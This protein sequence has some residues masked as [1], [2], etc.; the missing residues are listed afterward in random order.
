AASAEFT[1]DRRWFVSL[2]DQS[3]APPLE[4]L[5]GFLSAESGGLIPPLPDSLRPLTD[6]A[7]PSQV[8]FGGDP[9]A[10]T[11]DVAG[12]RFAQK[13][14]WTAV[15]G[16]TVSGFSVAVTAAK[17]DGGW[18]ATGRLLGSVTLGTG[19]N[20]ATFHVDMPIPPRAGEDWTI[21]LD[22]ASAIRIPT[23][24]QVLDLAGGAAIPLPDGIATLGGLDVTAL[25]VSFDPTVPALRHMGLRFAQ[26]GTW[27]IIPGA[28]GGAPALAASG[29]NAS[30]SVRTG[31]LAALGRAQGEITVLGT[32]V[33]FA[34]LKP[35]FDGDW[36]LRGAWNQPVHVPGLAD[37]A[38][39][40]G[41]DGTR[42]VLSAV[43][44]F[45]Q[46]FDLARLRLRFSGDTGRLRLV[47]FRLSTPV[48]WSVVGGRL[49][50][51]DVFAE[52]VVPTAGSVTGA[53]GGLV[54]VAGVT[55]QLRASRPTEQDPWTF[56]GGL[57]APV[58][59]D[60]L[61]AANQVSDAVLALPADAQS[62]WNLPTLVL[63]RADVT[64]VPQTGAYTFAAAL[65]FDGWSF[66]FGAATLALRQISGRVEKAGTDAPLV[67]RVLG[68]LTFASLDVQLGMQIGTAGTDTV[69][70]GSLTA[71][72]AQSLAV[73]SVAD[74]LAGAAGDAQWGAIVPDGL[75]TALSG[76]TRRPRKKADA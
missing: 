55:A 47:G 54:T 46:G 35:A 33:D 9:F 60:L 64:A 5:A 14:P 76:A 24:R 23:L 57:F 66:G 61:D 12:F 1:S 43:P 71:Q 65:D 75:P 6:L 30:L 15:P 63:R 50:V 49:S 51:H 36:E 8:F 19:E 59:L 26:D 41:R 11:L 22:E 34:L 40:M 38:E 3:A 58:T 13:Q 37:L 74:G 56:T 42:D 70:T 53:L 16:V 31:P 62:R 44:L 68:Q 52:L 25:T 45:G 17:G 10:G 7:T 20:A 4:T 27:I 67:A 32:Q 48:L 21:S 69:L 39:W 28:G 73:G 29:V 72:A 18:S 2:E